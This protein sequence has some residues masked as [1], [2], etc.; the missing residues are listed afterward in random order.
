TVARP[1]TR[2]WPPAQVTGGRFR[3]LDEVVRAAMAEAG[4]P[5]AAIGV[6]YRGE[7]DVSGY[8]VTNADYPQPVDRG[9]LFQIGSVTKTFTM[10]A[11]MRLVEQGRLDLDAPIRR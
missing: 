1:T 5:G 10:A 6:L 3:E 9:T 7:E 2:G 4:V 8:G 11:A